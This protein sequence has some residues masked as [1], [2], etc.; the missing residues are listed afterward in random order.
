[1]PFDIGI[2]TQSSL[3]VYK[4]VKMRQMRHKIILNVLT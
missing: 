1:M 3:A 2:P 4:A